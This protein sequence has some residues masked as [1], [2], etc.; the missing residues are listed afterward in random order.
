MPAA[1]TLAQARR[2]AL[3][4]QG[5]GGTRP[6]VVTVRRVQRVIDRVCQFQIDSVNVTVRAHLTPL[7]SRLGPY[8]PALLDRAMG[9]SPR[10]LFE[11][12]GHAASLID[13]NL[14]PELRFRMN[15]HGQDVGDRVRRI[16]ADHPE[17][18][19]RVRSEIAARGPLTAR[20]I[21]HQEQRSKDHWGW[22]WSSVKYLL[23]WWFWTG[24]LSSAGRNS[25]F[26]R[27]YDLT[28]R[29]IPPEVRS[30]PTPSVEESRLELIRRAG[31]ALGIATDRCLADY[32]RT[33]LTDTRRAIT[34]LVATGEL[35]PTPV[36]GWDRR[37]YLWHQASIP[38]GLRTQCLVSPFDSLVFER[39]RLQELFDLRYRIE[40]YVPEAQRHYGYYV[41]LFVMDEAITARV[42]LKADRVGGTLIAQASWLEPGAE[43][44]RS[45]VAA[46]LAQELRLMADWLGV[47]RV[48]V[49][50]R[51]TLADDL[52][53]VIRT[54]GQ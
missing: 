16:T 44:R 33:S 26:E 19:E 41:Y 1:L 5:F 8:D 52:A 38:R 24:E 49:R 13:V 11:F 37:T 48:S 2:I 50:P 47:E 40:I 29:V 51:G 4:A 28:E 25:Q 23:E 22:N 3:S 30:R 43:V 7:Y 12:W 15:A 17:L 42:D 10:R 27:L 34:T 35:V 32:F 39:T 46:R 21:E 20:Q 31:R 36:R 54:S 6:S 18:A 14:Q 45:E 9:A 53:S